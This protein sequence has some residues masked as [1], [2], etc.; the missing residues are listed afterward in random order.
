MLHNKPEESPE[1]EAKA[2]PD[3]RERIVDILKTVYDPEIPVD[4]Y[5]LGLIYEV[6]IDDS[7]NVK[8]VMT[9]TSPGCPVAGSLPTEV[10]YKVRSVEG[11]N[12][13]EVQLVWEPPWT[14]E[15]MSE[16]ARLQ[17]NM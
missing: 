6:Q 9:L 4:I 7:Q 13:A 15:M 8:V 17:L 11:V 12:T 10:E 3:L 5:E 1:K 14:P 16:A 2:S